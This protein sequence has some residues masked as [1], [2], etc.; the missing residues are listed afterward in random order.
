MRA[1]AYNILHH[2]SFLFFFVEARGY[3]FMPFTKFVTAA[4]V[5]S[6]GR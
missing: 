6:E 2:Y 4:R 1:G 5:C 3:E